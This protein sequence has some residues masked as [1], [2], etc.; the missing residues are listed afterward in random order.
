MHSSKVFR[1]DRDLTGNRAMVE[2][3]DQDDSLSISSS[4]K[5]VQHESAQE[6]NARVEKGCPVISPVLR[7]TLCSEEPFGE[8]GHSR[9]I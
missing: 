7:A 5:V 6:T 2:W 3:P 4:H 1:W 8:E 9:A